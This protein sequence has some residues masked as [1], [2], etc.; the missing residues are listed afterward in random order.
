LPNS[1]RIPVVAKEL[2]KLYFAKDADRVWN[3][4]NKNDIP[5]QFTA[6]GFK[7]TAVYSSATGSITLMLR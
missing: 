4:F 1:Y 6:N 2:F 7:V 3:Y 5:E